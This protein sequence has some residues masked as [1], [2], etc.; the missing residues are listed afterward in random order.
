MLAGRVRWDHRLDAA[1]GQPITEGVGV[2]G[3]VCEQSSRR[4]DCRQQIA[5]GR[6][7]MAIA[8]CDQEGD[9]ATSI[10]GQRMDF[11]G[12]PAARAADRL[13]EV[14]PFAP[15]AER[16]ALMCVESIDIVPMRPVEPVS[17]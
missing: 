9:G 5:C 6:Q 4:R 7:V 10:L 14:P 3:P 17:V 2:V 1:V 8:G 11:C 16:W 15:A 12:A 13:L